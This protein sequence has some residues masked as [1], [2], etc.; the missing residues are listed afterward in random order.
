[1]LLIQDGYVKT[2]GGEIITTDG[3]VITVPRRFPG[4]EKTSNDQRWRICT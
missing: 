2:V 1:M 3:S 4:A